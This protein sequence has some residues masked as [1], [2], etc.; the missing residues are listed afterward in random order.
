MMMLMVLLL[1][2]VPVICG[3]D[4]FS[5]VVCFKRFMPHP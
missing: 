5:I 3:D 1:V 2:A 4:D